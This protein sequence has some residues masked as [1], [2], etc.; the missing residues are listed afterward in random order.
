MAR[1]LAY[2]SFL[3]SLIDELVGL[4][5]MGVSSGCGKVRVGADEDMVRAELTVA[6][7]ASNKKIEGPTLVRVDRIDDKRV[8]EKINPF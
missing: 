7:M 1:A 2:S 3:R 4:P 5:Q 8:R 6:T